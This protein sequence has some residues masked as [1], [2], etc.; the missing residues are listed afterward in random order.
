M[1]YPWKLSKGILPKSFILSLFLAT[2]SGCQKMET[3][4]KMV[5]ARFIDGNGISQTITS[6]DQLQKLHSVDFLQKQP[7]K[8]MLRIF[9]K[10]D[11]AGQKCILT[12]YHPNGFLWQYL[13][14]EDLTANGPY[15]EYY[16]NGKKKIEASVIAGPCDVTPSAQ[17]EWKFDGLSVVFNQDGKV[18]AEI[19]YENGELHGEAKYYSSN[20]KLEK[21]ISYVRGMMNGEMN[22]FFSDGSLKKKEMYQQD[23]LHGHALG[24]FQGE[25]PAYIEEYDQGHLIEGIY[26]N[27]D[28]TILSSVHSGFGKKAIFKNNSLQSLIEYKRGQVEGKISTFLPTGELLCEYH[29]KDGK[30]EGEEIEYYLFK[31]M[32]NL[33]AQTQSPKLSIT[34]RNGSIEG[35]IKT[36]YENGSTQSQKEVVQNKKNGHA[37]CWYKD[38]SLLC[39]EEYENDLLQEGKYFKLGEKDP[40]SFVKNGA[41]IA[42]IYD[43][44]TG[45]FLR[46]IKYEHG[47]PI[48]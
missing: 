29:W 11:Q 17:Y 26:Y 34:W 20:E 25:E 3:E 42:T 37:I 15:L 6:Q 43:G 10:K 27:R 47:K 23:L 38:G 12:T 35:M 45:H 36:W 33:P 24:Y 32:E 30:K 31:E 40:V 39:M 13:E 46:K 22:E 9:S 19:P 48:L 44:K 4:E 18:V 14:G 7:Y 2:F 1:P 28:G 5:C 21:T 41:G 8:K 16:P